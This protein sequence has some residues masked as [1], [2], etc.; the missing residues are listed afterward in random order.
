MYK[1]LIYALSLAVVTVSCAKVP[2]HNEHFENDFI[3]FDYN[4]AYKKTKITSATHML[5]KLEGNNSLFSISE[6]NYGIEPNVDAWNDEIYEHYEAFPVSDGTLVTTEKRE[7][8]TKGGSERGLFILSNME[9]NGVRLKQAACLFVHRGNLYVIMHASPGR[10][11]MNSPCKEFLELLKGLTLKRESSG[12]NEENEKNVTNETNSSNQAFRVKENT[13]EGYWD[14]PSCTYV[15]HFYGF[16]WNLNREM[17][18]AQETGTE[19]HTVFKARA[20]DL[21]LIVFVHANE[22]NENLLNSDIWDRAEEFKRVQQT[23]QKKIGEQLGG[24][25]KTIFFEKTKLWTKNALKYISVIQYDPSGIRADESS[26]SITYKTFHKGRIFSVNI[27]MSLDLADYIEEKGIDVEK[28]LL[29]GF[30]FTA[31]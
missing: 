28:E 7:I 21:P 4:S 9:V 30:K 31:K 20:K 13:A 12:T 16:S 17:G 10:Y 11:Q 1:L 18:W 5:L 6:W 22:Y 23:E 26:Y 15:N 27:E 25:Y 24:T 14:A 2:S 19:V 8:Q 3:S 29:S